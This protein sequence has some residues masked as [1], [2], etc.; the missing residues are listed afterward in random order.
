[1]EKQ[2]ARIKYLLMKTLKSFLKPVAIFRQEKRS[3]I[4]FQLPSRVCF[5]RV[6]NLH[7][8]VLKGGFLCHPYQYFITY[9]HSRRIY[10]CLLAC[11][12][13][14]MYLCMYVSMYLC[15]SVYICECMHSSMCTI[16][17][18]CMHYRCLLV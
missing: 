5:Y 3:K 18:T 9:I 15:F 13:L 12:C 10:V 14:R 17:Y 16:A 2:K 1:M 4:P 7:C 6:H 11:M 8:I